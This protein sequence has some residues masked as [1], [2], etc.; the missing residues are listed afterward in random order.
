MEK[1]NVCMA[2]CRLYGYVPLARTHNV[3]QTLTFYV[4]KGPFFVIYILQPEDPLG[5]RK[6]KFSKI[7]SPPPPQ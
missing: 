6:K 5:S 4:Q 3:V 2:L 1:S 7:L